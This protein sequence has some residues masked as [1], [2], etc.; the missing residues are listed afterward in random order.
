VEYCQQEQDGERHGDE[1]Q[2]RHDG[3]RGFREIP[4]DDAKHDLTSPLGP[5][6][7]RT[8]QMIDCHLFG[9]RR[10]WD[11]SSHFCV[12]LKVFRL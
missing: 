1:Q 5:P 10:P 7:S 8:T 11:G 3:L 2:A 9:R 12:F 4:G 6:S